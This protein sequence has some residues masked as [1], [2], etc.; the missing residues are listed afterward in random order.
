VKFGLYDNYRYI[1]ASANRPSLRN[2]R[3][4]LVRTSHAKVKDGVWIPVEDLVAVRVGVRDLLI[5][6][7][8]VFVGPAL[9][10]LVRECDSDFDS[11]VVLVGVYPSREPLV[12]R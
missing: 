4:F 10:S 6:G 9:I 5:P 1:I 8:M 3:F 11:V 2:T 12:H 7:A